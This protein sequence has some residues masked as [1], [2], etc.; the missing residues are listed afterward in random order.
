M[1]DNPF[2]NRAMEPSI[3]FSKEDARMAGMGQR[4]L[5]DKRKSQPQVRGL[6]SL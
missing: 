2:E 6:P 4:H 5:G 3:Y 1:I